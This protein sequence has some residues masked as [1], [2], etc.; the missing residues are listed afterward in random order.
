MDTFS[1]PSG[2][3][4]RVCIIDSTM[5][6]HDMPT[7]LLLE[8]PM[9]GLEKLPSIGSWSF[10]VKSSTGESVLFDLGA[11]ADIET[12]LP[13]VAGQIEQLKVK[14]E[15]EKNVADIL[16]ENGIDPGTIKSV[17]WRYEPTIPPFIRLLRAVPK[18][19]VC[20]LQAIGTGTIPET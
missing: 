1:V 8:P 2:A 4:A 9:D 10:L 11:A 13:L 19:N 7:S 17:I 3:A 6:I 18:S 15:V 16:K 20:D 12:S 14:I 5:R